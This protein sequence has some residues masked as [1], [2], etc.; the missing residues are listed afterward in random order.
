M[1]RTFRRGNHAATHR[2][3]VL[4]VGTASALLFAG[5]AAGVAPAITEGESGQESIEAQIERAV[6]AG[7]REVTITPGVY[8]RSSTLDLGKLDDFTVN[9]SGVTIIQTRLVQALATGNASDLT[10]KGLTIDYDP[11]PFTQGR[12]T[13]VAP[14][15]KSWMDV[16]ISRGYSRRDV[17]P[18]RVTVFDPESRLPKSQTLGARVSWQNQADGIARSS[19]AH[20]ARVG[21]IVTFAGGAEAGASFGITAGGTN[22]VFRD[23]K[24]HAAPGMGFMSSGGEGNMRLDGFQLVPGPPPPGGTEKPILSSTWDG[25]QFQSVKKGPTV[26]NSTVV[27]AGDD[28]MSIQGIG[29][30]NVVK[31]DGT[32]AWV[33][34]ADR[35]RMGKKGD[36]LQRFAGGPTA[37]ITSLARET[38]T[39]VTRLAGKRA[40]YTY[41]VTLDRTSP[42][43]AGEVVTDID[44]MGNDFVFRNNRV[45]SSGRGFLLKARNGSIENNRIRG[46][47][48][49]SVST[50]LASNSHANAGGKLVIKGNTFTSALWS[51]GGLWNSCQVGAVTFEGEGAS[52]RP[53]PDVTIEENVFQDIRGLNLNISELRNGT[54][55]NNSFRSPQTAGYSAT[56]NRCGIPK[57]SVVHVRESDGVAF[58]GNT[59]D[60]IGPLGKQAVTVDE[61]SVSGVTGLPQGVRV[62]NTPPR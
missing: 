5:A 7:T 11:L 62:G 41:K 24:L 23:V 27:N 9:A 59:V 8:R 43:K 20:A 21:D 54:V 34:F 6:A 37:T 14:D 10:V 48:A 47:N 13:A 2:K 60:R 53:F 39:A 22:T 15:G 19:S 28:S 18:D 31:T 42:W 52:E 61:K 26:E 36:R 38:D 17:L 4:M 56:T 51:G 3:R 30:V 50:E 40:D 45:D 35:Y 1:K 29:T 46:A 33:A 32:T 57:T 25:I 16:Q 44:R 58:T 55:R 12:V 49:I